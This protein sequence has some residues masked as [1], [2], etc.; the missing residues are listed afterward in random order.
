MGLFLFFRHLAAFAVL[1]VQQAASFVDV[2]PDEYFQQFASCS[3]RQ[4]SPIH[5][6]TEKVVTAGK[7]VNLYERMTHR[8]MSDIHLNYT[9]QVVSLHGQFGSMQLFGFT[10][11]LQD[12]QVRCPAEHVVDGHRAEAELQL[13]LRR[14]GPEGEGKELIIISLLLRS[15]ADNPLLQLSLQQSLGQSHRSSFDLLEMLEKPLGG[16]FYHYDGSLTTPPCSETVKWFVLETTATVSEA[17]VAAIRSLSEGAFQRP[18]QPLGG[19]RV[20]K[21]SILGCGLES[22]MLRGNGSDWNYIVPQCW[23]AHYGDCGGSRQSPINIPVKL[24]SEQKPQLSV[25]KLL[26]SVRY[27]DGKDLAVKNSG[28]SLQ[29]DA[30]NGNL[31]KIHFQGVDYVVLQFHFHFPAE[32]LFDGKQAAG[33]MHIV[34]QR[35]GCSGFEDLLVIGILLQEGEESSF[36]RR[37]GLPGDAPKTNL[38]PLHAIKEPVN[39]ATEFQKQLRGSFF[40]YEGSLTTPPCSETVKWLVLT[41]TFSVAREQILAFKTTIHGDPRNSR[42]AQL[43]NGRPIVQDSTQLGV[44]ELRKGKGEMG[45]PASAP[46]VQAPWGYLYPDCWVKDYPDCGG[47]VQSP[48]NI[49]R[50]DVEHRDVLYVDLQAAASY[51]AAVGKNLRNMGYNLQV[52]AD[53]SDLGYLQYQGHRYLVRQF[54]IHC[55]AEHLLDGEAFACEVHVV[56][57][58]N[59][60]TGFQDLLVVGILYESGASFEDDAFLGRVFNLSGTPPGFGEPPAA[61]RGAVDLSHEYKDALASGFY[62]YDGSLTTPP[63]TESVTWFLLSTTMKM[64]LGQLR[65][66]K[67][68]YVDPA[69]N[70]LIQLRGGRAIFRNGVAADSVGASEHRRLCWPDALNDAPS[71]ALQAPES[72]SDDDDDE[73]RNFSTCPNL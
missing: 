48:I 26:H 59:G 38:Q 6:D 16:S 53:G 31:G 40:H 8:V 62:N 54:H 57:Q 25:E 10:F 52:D 22:Q 24:L 70:R 28:A 3:G 56:H 61:I 21:D 43:M 30:V 2:S 73:T 69:N 34:H 35:L 71:C 32:H 4:Q 60:S 41:E 66:F 15:G 44:A 5:I 63:C 13:L 49:P 46:Q 29:V 58:R 64:S 33:E 36:L 42:G 51:T 39:L 17:Q 37:L 68:L 67:S 14:E 20:V 19:R 11:Y 27:V 1:C 55:P 12:V 18:L 23:A 7:R 45:C 65:V 9:G 47:R 72:E 50:Q